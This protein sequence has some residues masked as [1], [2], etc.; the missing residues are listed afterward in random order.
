LY[1]EEG[2][3]GEEVSVSLDGNHQLG[4]GALLDL[5]QHTFL[6]SP[7]APANTMLAALMLTL[8]NLSRALQ[9]AAAS[10]SLILLRTNL[11][12]YLSH[13]HSQLDKAS[14]TG[15]NQLAIAA[16][17]LPITEAAL[18]LMKSRLAVVK[19]HFWTAKG[20][21]RKLKTRCLGVW[22]SGE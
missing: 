22:V 11:V 10:V 7:F 14:A 18:P 13:A 1:S 3:D 19:M 16:R 9:T 6:F 8:G 5:H 15:A 20:I 2:W 17:A 21:S 12:T 4:Y